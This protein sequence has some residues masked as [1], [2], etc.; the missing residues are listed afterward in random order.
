MNKPT[1]FAYARRAFWRALEPGSD[2]RRLRIS[3]IENST[4]C[5]AFE[6]VFLCLKGKSNEYECWPYSPLD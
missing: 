1:F 5:T 6:A 2:R 4:H 3:D